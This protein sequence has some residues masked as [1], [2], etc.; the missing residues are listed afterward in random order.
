[1][2]YT[3]SNS[4]KDMKSSLK[5]T[6]EMIAYCYAI[7][8]DFR[9]DKTLDSIYKLDPELGTVFR[10]AKV[11]YNSHPQFAN[12]YLSM[13]ESTEKMIETLL[14]LDIFENS[15]DKSELISNID[16][17]PNIGPSYIGHFIDIAGQNTRMFEM[18]ALNLRCVCKPERWYSREYALN[19]IKMIDEDLYNM[20]KVLIDRGYDE[21]IDV[22]IKHLEKLT[23]SFKE[24]F[25]M[26]SPKR[27]MFS[28]KR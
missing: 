13:C 10:T 22:L 8:N 21:A 9:V 20:V 7:E 24:I 5:K 3:I 15:D 11:Y 25:E 14:D 12:I 19:T 26:F 27:E 17:N 16:E 2:M 1:M 4:K 18:L 6:R 23:N 28:P